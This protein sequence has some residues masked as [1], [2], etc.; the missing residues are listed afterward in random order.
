ML[1]ENALFALYPI[2]AG[3]AVDAILSGRTGQ[4][5]LYAL[6]VF[7]A[8]AV[9][10]VR[11][12][13]D[14][15]AFTSIYAALAS[16]VIA[17][18]RANGGEVGRTAARVALSREFVDFFEN[19]F[20]MIFTSVVSTVGAVVMLAFFEPIVAALCVVILCALGAL[21][22]RY[23]HRN[24]ALYFRLNNR[25]EKEVSV[26]E[27]AGEASVG[28]HYSVLARLR[29]AIST[30]EAASYLVVG[31]SAAA[32][33]GLAIVTLSL[34]GVSV[35]HVTTVMTYIWTFAISLDDAPRLIE[36]M[37]KLKDIGKRIALEK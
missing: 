2:F 7:V 20:P 18:E 12:K 36:D 1:G 31:V 15:K 30:R 37:S 23:V 5:L 11:R 21:L 10:A 17:S 28:R 6:F 13:V 35:G 4:A 33:F 32:T 19:S 24:D 25:L 34:N 27:K 29:T 26:I 9:G 22:P 16:Q 8:W 14:T 3:W